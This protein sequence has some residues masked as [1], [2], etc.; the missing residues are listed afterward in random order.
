M[1]A[2]AVGRVLITRKKEARGSFFFRWRR[3]KN[4]RSESPLSIALSRAISSSSMERRR[5]TCFP[6]RGSWFKSS[7]ARRPRPSS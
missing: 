2:V 7:V 3:T 6:A 4:I 1:S 5:G